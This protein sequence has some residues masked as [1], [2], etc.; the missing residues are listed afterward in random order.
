MPNV[1]KYLPTYVTSR[2]VLN[3]IQSYLRFYV[4]IQSAYK[5][6]RPKVFSLITKKF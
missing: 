2:I 4:V 5:I 1:F 3:R 6:S